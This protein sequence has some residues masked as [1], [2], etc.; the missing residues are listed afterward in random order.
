MYLII[1][2]QSPMKKIF[3]TLLLLIALL[4][5]YLLFFPIS[6]E[7]VSYTP[8]PDP[9]LKGLFAPN[10]KLA[11]TQHLIPGVGIGPEDVAMSPDSM[12]YS[13]LVDGR[14]IKFDRDGKT[15]STF[16]NTGGRPLGMQFDETGNLIIADAIK[17]LIAV[18]TL[19]KVTVLT[20]KVNGKKIPFADD[21]D[22]AENGTI[23]F[24]DASQRN[25]LHELETEIM[26]L[27]PTGRLLSYNP[28][29]KETKVELEGLRF[30][31]GVALGPGD[32]YVLINETFGMVIQKFWLRGPKKGTK[33]IFVNELP[34]Y[35]DNIS[36]NGKGIFWVAI[37]AIRLGK[38]LEDLYEKPFLRKM[39]M[40]LPKSFLPVQPPAKY[41][42]VIGLNT[43]G[44]VIHNY[45]DG[46]GKNFYI[47]SVN[48]FGGDLY[49]GS[50][51]ME[52]VGRFGRE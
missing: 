14:I 20:D 34:G 18:D 2:N 25:H 7:P 27:Q 41:G 8:P 46:S 44:Q 48:E 50:L 13:G 26:E 24:S 38:D 43:K 5:A 28:A 4:L 19:G 36:Y 42:M 45:Q 30:A 33:E 10:T 3:K 35:P 52:A 39:I 23:Y 12:L 22:I 49:L 9:G 40:R 17:G 16:A 47:T 51:E 31:N 21:L 37:P 32:E 29:T 11:K 1:Q 15:Q 6:A